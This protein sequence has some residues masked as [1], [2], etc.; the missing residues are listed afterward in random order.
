MYVSGQAG[1]LLS[2]ARV[3]RL[4]KAGALQLVHWEDMA[5][6][7]KGNGSVDP[8]QHQVR[9]VHAVRIDWGTV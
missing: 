6:R 5:I 7:D 1:P 3:Q 4:I 9:F 8:F 2:D